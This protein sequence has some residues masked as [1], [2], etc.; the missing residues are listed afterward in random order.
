MGRIY[1]VEDNR[2]KMLR[3]ISEHHARLHCGPSVRELTVSMGF[4][5]TNGT[6]FWLDILKREGKITWEPMKSRTIRLTRECMR[7]DA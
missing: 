7:H 4:S 5:S 3:L 6:R 2:T 1:P